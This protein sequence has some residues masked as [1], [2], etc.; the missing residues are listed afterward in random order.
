M[1]LCD[2]QRLKH[3]VFKLPL[4]DG[5]VTAADARKALRA[6]AKLEE[7][8][9]EREKAADID[10]DGK[11]TAADARKILRASAGLEVM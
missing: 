2:T 9:P 4:R 3:I 7:L 1:L 11:V 5:K 10:G 8:T 6:S